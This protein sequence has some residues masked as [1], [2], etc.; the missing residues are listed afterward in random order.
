MLKRRMRSRRQ[1]KVINEINM[2]PLL[3]LTF[4]LLVAFMITFPALEQGIVVSL[5]KG[6]AQALDQKKPL[7]LS[8]KADGSIYVATTQVTME[9]LVERLRQQATEFPDSTVLVRGDQEQSYGKI[10]AVVKAINQTGSL[11]MALVV[12]EE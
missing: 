3:D 12:T 11:K 9:E 2:N 1:R 10:M 6:K 8:I 7:S 4:L 5:P